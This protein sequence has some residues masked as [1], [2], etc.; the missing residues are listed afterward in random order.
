MSLP[1]RGVS[2][3][4]RL[5]VYHTVPKDATFIAY[6]QAHEM[7]VPVRNRLEFPFILLTTGEIS[8]IM[9]PKE[10][11]G[12]LEKVAMGPHLAVVACFLPAEW[13]REETR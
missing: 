12:I 5:P 8:A 6:A 7:I 13:K 9:V 1:R 4:T 11:W 2:N 10:D 3:P